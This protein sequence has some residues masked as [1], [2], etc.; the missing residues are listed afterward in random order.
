[1]TTNVPFQQQYTESWNMHIFC[2]IEFL[3]VIVG[4]KNN[5][6]FRTPCVKNQFHLLRVLN[7]RMVHFNS[8]WFYIPE[9]MGTCRSKCFHYIFLNIKFQ[10][11]YYLLTLSYVLGTEELCTFYKQCWNVYVEGILPIQVTFFIFL[12]LLLLL[13]NFGLHVTLINCY[14]LKKV[15]FNASSHRILGWPS[16]PPCGVKGT[17]R[18]FFQ[19]P[20][21]W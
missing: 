4:K 15:R 5:I 12:E 19:Y 21:K 14:L 18:A 2:S 7:F 16:L 1:M 17:I 20:S 10:F 6:M 9:I 13:F 8:H 3:M 11:I